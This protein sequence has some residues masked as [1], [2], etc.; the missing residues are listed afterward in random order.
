MRPIKL[1]MTAFG[2]YAG[3]QEIDFRE[4][5]DAGLFGIYGPV[6]SGKSSIFSAMSF[7]LFGEGAKEEQAPKSMRSDYASPDV[8][9]DVALLFELG[10]KR[11][12]VRRQPE[13][14]RPKLKGGGETSESHR[15]WLFDA[16]G[17]DVDEVSRKNC[18]TV[19]AEVKVGVV[20]SRICEI[21]G[22]DL[23]QFRQI[24][25]LP[26]GKFERF[27][28][29]DSADR[30][31]ILRG[32]FDVSLYRRMTLRIKES[33]AEASREVEIGMRT[34]SLM[35]KKAGFEST[36]ELATAIEDADGECTL[37][38]NERRLADAELAKADIARAAGEAL[39]SQF[40]QAD[41][42]VQAFLALQARKP[43]FDLIKKQYDAAV[44][45]RQLIDRDEAV[46]RAKQAHCKAKEALTNAQSA[47]SDAAKA[48]EVAKKLFDGLEAKKGETEDL[49]RRA[50]DMDRYDK[51]LRDASDLKGKAN[52]A[53]L[54]LT[55][56]REAVELADCEV[57]RLAGEIDAHRTKTENA[58][59]EE[60]ARM[61]LAGERETVRNAHQ[62]AIEYAGACLGVTEAEEAS[63]LAKRN[64]EGAREKVRLLLAEMKESETEFLAG[65]AQL[66]ASQLEHGSPCPVC[67]SEEHPSPAHGHAATSGLEQVW[68]DAAAT[69][70]QENSALA[71][72]ET[73]LGKAEGVFEDRKK[74]LN[75]L[76]VPDESVETLK[77]RVSQLN[78]KIRELGEPKD[79]ACLTG[80]LDRLKRELGEAQ[81][82]RQVK[83]KSKEAAERHEAGCRQSYED[84]IASVPELYRDQAA[85]VDVRESIRAEI[86]RRELAL[87]QARDG[88]TEADKKKVGA[89]A[90]LEGANRRLGECADE[91]AQAEEAFELRRV[92]LGL[93][94]EAFDAARQ[95]IGKIAE[96]DTQVSDYRG[97]VLRAEG[98]QQEL[99][100]AVEKKDRPDVDALKAACEVSRSRASDT[101]RVAAETTARRNA[102]VSMRDTLETEFQRLHRIEVETAPVRELAAAFNG[103]NKMRT[104]LETFA[105]GAMFDQVLEAANLRLDPMTRGRYRLE[106]DGQSIGGKKRRGLDIRVHDIQTGRPRAVSTLSGG[107]TFLAALSLALGL[108]DIVEMS[109]GVIRL[110]TIFIDEGFG[111]LDSDG[112]SGTLDHV[113]DVLQDIVGDRRAVGLISHVSV[114][115]EAVPNGFSVIKGT[116][117]SR[118]ERRS[119]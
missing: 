4:A 19:L 10:S 111:S 43:E 60:L 108:S 20:N 104:D 66:L 84:Q 16:S 40:E 85:L 106:R 91:I 88:L 98:R 15:A 82:A 77:D 11:Y 28:A 90:A 68:R 71:N 55:E 6:G 54:A 41:N 63:R 61:R 81:K 26:Q 103:D 97:D 74:A 2:P 18:G 7:A 95:N 72:L 24:V 3:T 36:D 46:V 101:A 25:L 47:V 73:A 33:A 35:L 96:L 44:R 42:A 1:W 45:A 102:L 22:Y 69:Y 87:E 27:L 116:G 112:E 52:D 100:K 80:T 59:S 105:I 109:H 110:D 99:R 65:Q 8:L 62:R 119:I 31:A 117:G 67:G 49:K 93:S 21:L 83:S 118:V 34:R 89:S 14:M 79:I 75:D 50:G 115:Q 78:A 51:L 32:L 5:T 86:E 107:E 13:Q 57:E 23:D 17:I 70:D 58:Q 94:R 113:L 37:K 29:S 92:E 53:V 12:F 76:A 56:A 9:T 64:V 38:D 114:V 48:S 39:A 30:L